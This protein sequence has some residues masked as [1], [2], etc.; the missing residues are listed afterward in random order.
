MMFM[1][2]CKWFRKYEFLKCLIAVLGMLNDDLYF[3]N[4]VTYFFSDWLVFV[5]LYSALAFGLSH[6]PMK[7]PL[8][9][10]RTSSFNYL[11]YTLWV[12]VLLYCLFNKNIYSL[13]ELTVSEYY[14]TS[15][16]DLRDII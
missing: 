3:E 14:F 9:L 1:L 15:L 5:K 8:L 11:S 6:F 10:L 4:L 13:E 16:S 2:R 7:N 12:S